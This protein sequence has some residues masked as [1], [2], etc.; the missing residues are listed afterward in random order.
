[1]I[2]LYYCFVKKSITHRS[3]HV[4]LRKVHVSRN[5]KHYIIPL[6]HKTV[7]GTISQKWSSFVEFTS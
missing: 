7:I 6:Y 3:R 1:M 2:L 5:A 4:R